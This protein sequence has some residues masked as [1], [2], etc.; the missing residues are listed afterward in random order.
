MIGLAERRAVQA[1]RARVLRN[2]P[3]TPGAGLQWL[4][5]QQNRA[6]ALRKWGPSAP[7]LGNSN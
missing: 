3:R 2:T 1:Y 4:L 7:G 6:R 5:I